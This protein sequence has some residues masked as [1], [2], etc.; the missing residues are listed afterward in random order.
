MKE[1]SHIRTRE[2]LVFMRERNPLSERTRREFSVSEK[3]RKTT[4]SE[5]KERIL[6]SS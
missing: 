4:L 1:T 5:R 6:F 2:E 3:K